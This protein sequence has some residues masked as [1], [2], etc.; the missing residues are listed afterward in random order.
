M[1]R[2]WISL[3]LAA[4]FLMAQEGRVDFAEPLKLLSCDPASTIPC[5]RMK[6]NLVDSKGAP[7]GVQMPPPDKLAGAIK[8]RVGDQEVTPFY[9]SAAGESQVKVRG[10]AALVVVDISGSMMIKLSSGETRFDAAKRAVKTFL[11]GFEEGADRVAVVP[12][13]SHQ[14]HEHIGSAVFARTKADALSQVDMLPVP[15]AKNNTALFSAV[16][17][18]L[19]TLEAALPKMQAESTEGFE[20]M[21]IVLTD[22]SNEV[23]RGDDLGL[24]AGPAGLDQAERTS[25]ASGI[26]VIAVG[27]GE[28]GAIDENALK[29]LSR[30][31]YL[32]TD[33]D[34]LQK[35]FAFTRTLLNNRLTATIASPFPDR[36][37][38]AG[39][40]LP[41]H[42]ELK[43]ADGR[44]LK[45]GEQVWSAPQMGVPVYAGKC[46][47]AELKAILVAAPVSSGWMAIVRPIAVLCG[48]GLL[49][50][51]MWF[52][53]PRLIWP[54]QYIGV[55]PGAGQGKWS[56]TTVRVKDGVFT[57]RPAPPGFQSGPQGAN[58][59][60]RGSA[61]KT[62]VNP[63]AGFN[64][65]RLGNRQGD[66]RPR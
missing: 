21:V 44:V 66:D 8:V 2:L 50:I 63:G 18:G 12:F 15:T 45:S 57:N 56:S 13:E 9:A 47:P 7:L 24:L 20:T 1:R 3:L 59:A 16:V 54:E 32:A 28:M 23:L 27:F 40:S 41:F 38:L 6:L 37:S 51:V 55:L 61:D 22:G 14:V 65:T 29:R 4:P 42:V 53:I 46:S 30:K 10:R 31:Y 43:L 60:P 62:V 52:W 34:S 11:Q 39:Q 36:A 25:K 17:Y 58:L 26:P 64:Q 49:L 35:I 48:L 19:E 5:F 33:Y